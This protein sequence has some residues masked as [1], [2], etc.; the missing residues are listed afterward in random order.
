MTSE[1]ETHGRKKSQ[2]RIMWTREINK[3]K[4][5]EQIENND[6]REI[7]NRKKVEQPEDNNKRETHKIKTEEQ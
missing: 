7:H 2:E 4:K 6:K 3:I 5:S 1:N